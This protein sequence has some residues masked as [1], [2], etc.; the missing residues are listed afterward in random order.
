MVQGS[1][2]LYE[3]FFFF[4][5]SNSS[6]GIQ[7]ANMNLEQNSGT[8]A[9]LSNTNGRK[10]DFTIKDFVLFCFVCSLGFGVFL[11]LLPP[12]IEVILS[13]KCQL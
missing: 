12:Q 2:K 4:F 10:D 7:N 11:L 1:T 9:L 13:T 3:D 5:G 6:K 8:Q